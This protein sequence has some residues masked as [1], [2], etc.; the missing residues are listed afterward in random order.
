MS[1]KLGRAGVLPGMLAAV[2]VSA[3]VVVGC[4]PAGP[5]GDGTVDVTGR[6]IQTDPCDPLMIFDL[7][8][9]GQT[10]TGVASETT[11]AALGPLTGTI[12]L[13]LIHI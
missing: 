1:K 11:G 13:S 6:W 5:P 2:V 12:T 7:T 8:Q 10:V 9:I 3:L 4:P